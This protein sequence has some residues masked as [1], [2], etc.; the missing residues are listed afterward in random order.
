MDG[1]DEKI[2]MQL[3]LR[4]IDPDE[5]SRIASQ[6]GDQLVGEQQK[7]NQKIVGLVKDQ[8]K[9]TEKEKLDSIQ[10]QLKEEESKYKAV[11]K[12][13]AEE[14][15]AAKSLQAVH[16]KAAEK[17][18]EM[19]RD[20]L[21]NLAHIKEIAEGIH[22]G[23]EMILGGYEKVKQFAEEVIRTTQVYDSLK[24]SINGLREATE[25]EVADMDLIIVKNRATQAGLELSDKDFATVAQRAKEYANALGVDVKSGLDKLIDGLATGNERVLKKA[26]AMIDATKAEQEYANAIGKTA[27]DL[28]D[29]EKRHARIEAALKALE[30]ANKRAGESGKNFA[31]GMEVVFADIQ[32]S[33]NRLLVSI[34]HSEFLK[35]ALF[36][37]REFI[38]YVSP[39]VKLGKGASDMLATHEQAMRDAEKVE[40]EDQSFWENILKKQVERKAK[41]ADEALKKAADVAKKRAEV[42][43]ALSPTIRAMDRGGVSAEAGSAMRE[44]ARAGLRESMGISSSDEADE[45]FGEMKESIDD[46]T[47]RITKEADKS[48]EE[49]HKNSIEKLKKLGVSENGIAFMAMFGYDPEAMVNDA[50]AQTQAL[51]MVAGDMFTGLEGGAKKV[52]QAIGQTIQAAIAGENDMPL[53][54]RLKGVLDALGTE[55]QI[56]AIGA[57]A[58]AAF[59]AATGNIPGATAAGTAAGLFEAAAVAAGL[60]SRAIGTGG[61]ADTAAHGG[62]GHTG[63]V[64]TQSRSSSLSSGSGRSSGAGGTPPPLNINVGMFLGDEA[65][66]GRVMDRAVVA[67]TNKYGRQIGGGYS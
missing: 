34:G 24:G 2:F 46:V 52:Q 56:K 15:R 65:E 41:D 27:K 61:S 47:D 57:A 38:S 1:M 53:K 48:L 40:Q 22:G 25:G 43:K 17:A 60:A 32:N 20:T 21:A 18:R 6:A 39:D 67:Y 37:A 29:E 3:V 49:I 14:E 10:R 26:G 13:I 8:S 33:W 54:K 19:E 66:L 7:L 5:A 63:N 58:E 9:A 50:D 45:M 30:Q 4:G 59:F 23:F 36:L 16:E 31:S 12:M 11:A 42:L 55:W 51:L 44:V 35:D 64:G 28:D 62:A